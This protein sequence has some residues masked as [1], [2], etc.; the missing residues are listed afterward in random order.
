MNV[1]DYTS[2]HICT[3]IHRVHSLTRETSINDSR[4][5]TLTDDQYFHC[6][7]LTVP[8]FLKITVDKGTSLQ[9]IFT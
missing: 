4:A 7:E 2:S 3:H 8:F 5:D 9:I 6:P 1:I